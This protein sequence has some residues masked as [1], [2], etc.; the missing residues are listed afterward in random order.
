MIILRGCEGLELSKPRAEK[1]RF[2]RKRFSGDR[3]MAIRIFP[4]RG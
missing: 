4:R 2:R 3:L 1:I